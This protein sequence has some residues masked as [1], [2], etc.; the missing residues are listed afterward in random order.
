MRP[1]AEHDRESRGA[2]A[3]RP[4]RLAIQQPAL[5]KY[6]LPVFQELARRPGIDLRFHYAT[7]WPVQSVEP[8]GIDAEVTPMKIWRLGRTPVYWH[9][10]QWTQATRRTSDVLLLS[11]DIHY[12]SLVPSLLRAK[13]AG[14][15]TI[16]WGHGYSKREAG[17]RRAMRDSIGK[18]A[19]CI[20]LY[21]HTAAERF[22]EDG[23][24]RER[25]FVALN[26]LDQASIQE[27]RVDWLKRPEDL[28]RFRGDRGLDEG[29]V[30][31]F[32]SRLHEDNGLDLLIDAGR[33]LSERFAGLRIVII[34]KGPDQ[35]RLE[36]RVRETR[37]EGT[38]LF[39]GAIYEETELAP[40]FLSASVFC[41]PANVGLS[42]LH[43]FGYGVP[44]V[45]SD[46]R[47]AQNPEID[48]LEPDVNGRLYTHGDAADLTRILAELLA[49]ET[50]RRRLGEAALRTATEMFTIPRMVDGMEQAVRYAFTHRPGGD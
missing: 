41:Y 2:A 1:P 32:V 18:L 30:I 38:V 24:P 45:T 19:T 7:N 39:P 37:L 25:V 26:S 46:R 13:L 6:R 35:P 34:G 50:L 15:S 47:E 42:L 31:L 28:A 40:W 43:A 22:I 12:A 20:L 17:W 33:A 11:W 9:P 14:V 3:D 29:P 10:P 44:V 27:A 48:A 8:V 16:L 5:P 36:A 4:I 49:D 23:W 21:N